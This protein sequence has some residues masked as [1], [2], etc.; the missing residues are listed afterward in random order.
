MAYDSSR[1]PPPAE[2]IP[3]RLYGRRRGHP[4]RPR[5][6]RLLEETL[7]RITLATPE[8]PRASFPLEAE[9]LWLEVG[10]GGGEHALE[11]ASKNPRVALIASEVFENGLC[12]L[13]THLVPE[14]EEATAP[15]PANLRL[16]PRDAR[17]L[18]MALPDASLDR[19]FLMFPDPWPKARHSKRRFV[20]PALL[21]LLA[22]KLRPGAEWRIASDDPTYQAWVDEVM[23]AQDLF[24]LAEHHAEH[25]EGWPRTR[26]EAKAIREGRN[27]R[28]WIWRRR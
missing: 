14:G 13:L 19:L 27:P 18:L 25:P 22:Q 6:Q 8:S 2:G 17:H 4:L 3:D 23:G 24:E 26:Y 21:P 5:Q 15:L 9:A 16:W 7:P 12:S 1:P 11:L 28:W 20:H 10:F